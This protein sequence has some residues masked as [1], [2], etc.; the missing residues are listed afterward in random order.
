MVACVLGVCIWFLV[1]Y[2]AAGVA[3]GRCLVL[4]VWW[5]GCLWLCGE[6]GGLVVVSLCFV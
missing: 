2:L 1:G 4:V 5:F 3:G 6:F